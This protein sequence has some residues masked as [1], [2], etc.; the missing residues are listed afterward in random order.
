MALWAT[1]ALIAAGLFAGSVVAFA[2]DRV[3]AW[4]TMSGE[5]FFRD[6]GHTINRADRIQPAFLVIA[7][8]SGIAFSLN[9]GGTGRPLG[10]ISAAGFLIV[11]FASLAVLVPLQRR[12]LAHPND[13]EM[14]A[15]RRRW[16]SGHLGRTA[17]SVVSFG[18][19]AGAV[20]LSLP[21]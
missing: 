3:S 7:I 9:A 17:L 21:D 14:D 13:P 6:F 2:W 4:R 1:I 15:M 20:A 8:A 10:F 18:L 16:F 19:L 11:L 12:M 5:P